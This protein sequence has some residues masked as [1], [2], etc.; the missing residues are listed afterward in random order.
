LAEIFTFHKELPKEY[1]VHQLFHRFIA[2][3][4]KGH[5][6]A[7]LPDRQQDQDHVDLG[8]TIC[9]FLRISGSQNETNHLFDKVRLIPS[10]LEARD[11]ARMTIVCFI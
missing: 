5:V 2:L 6:A 10:I 7:L 1:A 8:L 3:D 4:N 9:V 11:K